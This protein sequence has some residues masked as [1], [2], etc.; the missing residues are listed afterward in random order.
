MIN[1]LLQK[2][3]IACLNGPRH[4]HFFC[5]DAHEWPAF[6]SRAVSCS[7]SLAGRVDDERAAPLA[8]ESLSTKSAKCRRPEQRCCS[9]SSRV[10]REIPGEDI[11]TKVQRAARSNATRK[12]DDNSGRVKQQH[13]R[14]RWLFADSFHTFLE[15]RE[16]D[17]LVLQILQEQILRPIPPF[18]LEV[19]RKKEV[20]TLQLHA[21]PDECKEASVRTVLHSI[22]ELFNRLLEHPLAWIVNAIHR[23]AQRLKSA[24]Q[25][26]CVLD[27]IAQL[28]HGCIFLDPDAQRF[29]CT[30]FFQQVVDYRSE[31]V[32]PTSVTDFAVFPPAPSLC[33]DPEYRLPVQFLPSVQVLALGPVCVDAWHRNLGDDVAL[34]FLTNIVVPLVGIVH[35]QDDQPV[36]TR[37]PARF[38]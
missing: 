21:M 15:E 12:I 6:P 14:G 16:R 2:E 7:A 18:E 34:S 9:C 33:R 13:L 3:R 38:R 4:H 32:V 17:S 1:L 30:S 31:A 27:G 19:C 37:K 35:V 11:F 26:N 24:L 22:R 29:P 36:V 5:E 28:G 8:V 20:L 23:P 25:A 10:R